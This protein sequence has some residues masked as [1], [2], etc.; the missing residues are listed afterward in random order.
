MK[1]VSAATLALLAALI[2]VSP[3]RGADTVIEE[4][5]LAVAQHRDRHPVLFHSRA[6]VAADAAWRLGSLDKA[7]APSGSN[8]I[9]YEGTDALTYL[10]GAWGAI[11]MD[12]AEIRF[13]CDSQAV[14]LG[15]AA[16]H[17]GDHLLI[18]AHLRSYL[19][20]RHDGSDDE[21]VV[22]LVYKRL[23]RT[24]GDLTCTTWQLLTQ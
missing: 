3:S 22:N 5:A 14:A 12:A 2:S 18:Y 20:C 24:C 17:A 7:P 19:S 21:A 9:T 1:K 16:T 10:S 11:L 6:D 4:N 13:E 8:T 15:C 23:T